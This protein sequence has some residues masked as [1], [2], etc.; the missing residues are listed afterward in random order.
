MW[1][2]VLDGRRELVGDGD[3]T[4]HGEGRGVSVVACEGSSVAWP[5]DHHDSATSSKRFLL[6]MHPNHGLTACVGRGEGE[7]KGKGKGCALIDW[8]RGVMMS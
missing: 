5:R 1:E 8:W 3:W 6:W 7:G 2:E 4:S